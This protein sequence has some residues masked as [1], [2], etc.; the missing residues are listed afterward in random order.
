M[1]GDP[2]MLVAPFYHKIPCKTRLVN[3]SWVPH[4]I[5]HLINRPQHIVTQIYPGTPIGPEGRHVT[6]QLAHARRSDDGGDG[7][8]P[9]P[10]HATLLHAANKV[11]QW[12]GGF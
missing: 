12:N 3:E 4:F 2:I 7:E 8:P 6:P 1:H 5:V 9:C 10:A 11:S